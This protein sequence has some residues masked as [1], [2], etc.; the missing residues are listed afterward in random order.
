MLPTITPRT[1]PTKTG[2]RCGWS[3]SLTESPSFVGDLVDG[4][5][6]ADGLHAVAQLQLQL[7][8]GRQLH[9]GAQHAGDRHAVAVEE[10]QFVDRPADHRGGA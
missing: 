8:R 10:V 3:R 5:R 4:V 7:R 9:L 2:I 1:M 6:L